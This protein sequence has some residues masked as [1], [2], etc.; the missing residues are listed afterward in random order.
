MSGKN[1]LS[2]LIAHILSFY[3]LVPNTLSLFIIYYWKLGKV[4][5][6][7]NHRRCKYVDNIVS[8]VD[9]MASDSIENLVP[10]RFEGVSLYAPEDIESYLRNHYPDLKSPD[11]L[12]SL[13]ITHAP[14]RFSVKD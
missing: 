6:L 2:P 5:S 14:Y 8:S 7:F 1:F 13:W 11:M 3:S 10:V 12:E 9:R 4:S